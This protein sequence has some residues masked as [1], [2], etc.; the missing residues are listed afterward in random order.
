MGQS[1]AR[2]FGGARRHAL[3]DDRDPRVGGGIC[4]AEE[5]LR[6]LGPAA[7]GGR[8]GHTCRGVE[9]RSKFTVAGVIRR[10]VLFKLR[11]ARA[12]RARRG[13]AEVVPAD[14]ATATASA[15][16][17]ARKTV[18]PGASARAWCSKFL[19]TRPNRRPATG[20]ASSNARRGRRTCAATMELTSG[21][22][23]LAKDRV[24]EHIQK[25]GALNNFGTWKKC[26]QAGSKKP[27]ECTATGVPRR[28]PPPR[29]RR[30]RAWQ[31][32]HA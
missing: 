16:A 22:Y 14:A 24:G 6:G 2:G 29:S 26:A 9:C 10:K 28:H 19:R 27:D 31:S 3:P 23:R 7:G 1:K 8:D 11:T 17:D 21:Q 18:P 15:D 4:D 25:Q 20:T 30:R 13:P 32:A 5:A 12:R